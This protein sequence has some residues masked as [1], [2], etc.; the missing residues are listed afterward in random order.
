MIISNQN[1]EKLQK[2]G[3]ELIFLE[4]EIRF[5]KK[6]NTK[7]NYIPEWR[8]DKNAQIECPAIDLTLKNNKFVAIHWDWAPGPGPG[9]FHLI[10]DNEYDAINFIDNY[11]YGN[12]EYF[13]ARK[14]HEYL[15]RDTY[16][17]NEIEQ[18]IKQLLLKLSHEFGS[19]EISFGERGSYHKIPMDEWRLNKHYEENHKVNATIGLLPFELTKLRKKLNENEKFNYEDVNNISNLLF[20]LSI[21]LKE[22]TV[23]NKTYK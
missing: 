6:K 20:E 22:K 12:N 7:G 21:K 8:N 9:D 14:S 2:K 10:F 17:I 18:I 11:Y 1:I 13:E 23:V 3:L 5:I 19:N 15:S 16:N 4:K